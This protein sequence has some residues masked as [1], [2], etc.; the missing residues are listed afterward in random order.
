MGRLLPYPQTLTTLERLARDKHCSLLQKSVNY[1]SR[2]FYSTGPRYLLVMALK[3]DLI[4]NVIS[5]KSNLD[6][7]ES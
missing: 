2:K 1:D 4:K 7:S 3:A 6:L 5:S